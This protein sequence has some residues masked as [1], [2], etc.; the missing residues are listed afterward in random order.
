MCPLFERL[1]VIRERYLRDDIYCG[2]I[3]C[4]I[5]AGATNPV[6][7]AAGDATHKQFTTGHYVLPDTNIFL[8]QVG[9]PRSL[10]LILTIFVS[11]GSDRVSDFYPSHYPSTNRPGRS[12][13]QIPSV[14]QP[15]QGTRQ[16][17]RQND[18][19]LLQRVPIVRMALFSPLP[20]FNLAQ[21]NRCRYRRK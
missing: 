19:G 14:V 12:P 20:L 3:A 15:S 21:G 13:P 2:I 5:C 6:L 4:R 9:Y 17:R 8:S 16:G 7:P 10:H 11:D 18:L 1:T